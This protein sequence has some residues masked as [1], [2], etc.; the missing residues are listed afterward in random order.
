MYFFKNTKLI[1][2]KDEN[3]ACQPVF[4]TEYPGKLFWFKVIISEMTGILQII[5]N[6]V[7]TLAALTIS[8]V[9]GL[10]A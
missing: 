9:V 7:A 6:A 10:R 2:F 8:K 1:P 5:C 3:D 4:I